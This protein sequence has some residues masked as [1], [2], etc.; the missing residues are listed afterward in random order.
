MAAEQI[1]TFEEC[2]VRVI[3][4]TGYIFQEFL[5]NDMIAAE[6]YPPD[7]QQIKPKSWYDVSDETKLDFA[8]GAF[9]VSYEMMGYIWQNQFTSEGAYEFLKKVFTVEAYLIELM[10]TQYGI[11]GESNPAFIEITYIE[12][13]ENDC[14]IAHIYYPALSACIE[15][16]G[17]CSYIP[18][19]EDNTPDDELYQLL[20]SVPPNTVQTVNYGAFDIEGE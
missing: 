2:N 4:E 13:E 12:H 9:Q 8:D 3:K 5:T 16:G 15:W 10:S 7:W 1:E 18:E 20:S 19:C 17:V 14:T 11:A 6:D